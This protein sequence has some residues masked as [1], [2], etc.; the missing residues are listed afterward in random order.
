MA[1]KYPLEKQICD[2]WCWAAVAMSVDHY[3][4]PAA[5]STQ[6]TIAKGVL[7]IDECCSKSE[8][9]NK[10]A[11]LQD[12]LKEAGFSPEIIPDKLTFREIRKKIDTGVPVCAR[13][14]WNAGGA[15]F[16]V[17]CGYRVSAAGT[18]MVEIADP[19]FPS[20]L[21]LYSEFVSAYQNTQEPKGGGQW[22]A[23]FVA[24]PEKGCSHARP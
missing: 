20:S 3:F 16:V 17:V 23:S 13:I 7:Q 21:I 22:V 15:H 19:L 24:K 9:C 6:C 2:K 5:T 4:F 12:A 11:K 1:G 18:E 14:A 10:P 8:S